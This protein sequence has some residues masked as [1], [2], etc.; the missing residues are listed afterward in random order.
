MCQQITGETPFLVGVEAYRPFK[1][2]MGGNAWKSAVGYGL[3]SGFARARGWPLHVFLPDDLKRAF[4]LGGRKIPGTNQRVKVSKR[5]VE[6]A[7]CRKV[8]GLAELLDK[9]PKAQREHAAD[10][11]GHAYL[12]LVRHTQLLAALHSPRSS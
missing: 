5:E 4:G 11:A 10:A 7:V 1:G 3:A 8:D 6:V 9:L 12:V 2:R